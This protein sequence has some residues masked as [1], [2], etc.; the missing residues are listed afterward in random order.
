M[1]GRMHGRTNTAHA[2]TRARRHIPRRY[3]QTK[4]ANAVFTL[5][6]AERLSARGSKVVAACA[7][8][9][10]AATNLQVRR[11]AGGRDDAR[12]RRPGAEHATQVTTAGNGGMGSTWIMKCASNGT[13][14]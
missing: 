12:Q 2:R 9:G 7:A 8:P 3:H 14:R 6:L 11:H 10:L 13:A 4:L 1:D 5:A